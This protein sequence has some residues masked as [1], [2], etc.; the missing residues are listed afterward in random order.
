MN[1]SDLVRPEAD[2]NAGAAVGAPPPAVLN[3]VLSELRRL[4]GELTFR[5]IGTAAV[6]TNS[7]QFGE[8][9]GTPLSVEHT[10]HVQGDTL[11]AEI[12]MELSSSAGLP[13]GNTVR[14]GSVS[15]R[16]TLD[17]GEFVALG[18]SHFREPVTGLEGPV[19]YIVHWEE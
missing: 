4:H 6:A 18:E 9:R 3:D 11:N 13:I 8:V 15:L 14:T 17:R 12:S 2:I 1:D 5:V 19:F 10:A 7:G 16:T